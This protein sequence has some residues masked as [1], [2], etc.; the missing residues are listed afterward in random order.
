MT[1]GNDIKSDIYCSIMPATVVLRA[2]S[3]LEHTDENFSIPVEV[4]YLVQHER[5]LKIFL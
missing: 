4:N 1:L 5:P 3:S 2:F